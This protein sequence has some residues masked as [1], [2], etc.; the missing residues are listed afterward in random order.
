MWAEEKIA[1][2]ECETICFL[3]GENAFFVLDLVKCRVARLLSTCHKQW[4]IFSVLWW[5][6]TVWRRPVPKVVSSNLMWG[7]HWIFQFVNETFVLFLFEALFFSSMRFTESI[8]P[9][10]SWRND[11]WV[12]PGENSFLIIYMW[13]WICSTWSYQTSLLC[14]LTTLS[15]SERQQQHLWRSTLLRPP[16]WWY[17]ANNTFST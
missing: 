13:C 15:F 7:F 11:E 10:M 12:N 8:P 9:W 5:N 3:F 14:S 4:P 1:V 17:I 6:I 2:I 16:E